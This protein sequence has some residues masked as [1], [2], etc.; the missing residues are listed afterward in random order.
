MVLYGARP[1]LAGVLNGTIA[2]F[3]FFSMAVNKYVN[4]LLTERLIASM[5]TDNKQYSCVILA[6]VPLQLTSVLY[7]EHLF[8][9]G[10]Y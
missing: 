4:S 6:T 10:D 1:R 5:Q 9:E 8:V 3:V 7:S 2:V